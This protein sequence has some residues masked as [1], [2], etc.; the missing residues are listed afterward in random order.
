VT[1][2][3]LAGAAEIAAGFGADMAEKMGLDGPD[4]R[5]QL[6]MQMHQVPV[7]IP[8]LVPN[9]GVAVVVANDQMGPLTGYTWSL[10]RVMAT[11]YTAGTVAIYRNAAQIGYGAAG[12]LV[13]ELLFT[14]PQ[15]GTYT[16]GRGEMLLSPDDSL[17]L[18]ATGVTLSAGVTGIQVTG[19]ADQF[20]TWLLPDYLM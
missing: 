13:G 11:G 8:L 20:E 18:L 4:R 5:H 2:F 19:A 3:T 15:A 17:S 10:R 1:G 16:F 7:S 6:Y 9:T 12:Q 14:F